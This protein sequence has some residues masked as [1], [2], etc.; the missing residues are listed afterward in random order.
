M[1]GYENSCFEFLITLKVDILKN[2]LPTK[3]TCEKTNF[4]AN[5]MKKKHGF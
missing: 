4:K 2:Y 3:S 5:Y 1:E